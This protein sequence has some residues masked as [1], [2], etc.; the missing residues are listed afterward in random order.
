LQSTNAVFNLVNKQKARADAFMLTK[1]D[2]IQLE[3]N[4]NDIE[5]AADHLKHLPSTFP[6]QSSLIV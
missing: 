1:Y 6:N 4:A 2:T 5:K 3:T